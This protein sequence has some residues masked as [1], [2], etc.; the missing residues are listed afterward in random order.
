MSHFFFAGI[1]TEMTF[2]VKC[3][4]CENMIL[5]QTA[6]DNGGLCGQCFKI[7]PNERA[8][9]IL[10]ASQLADGSFFHLFRTELA[11][12][13]IPAALAE[14]RDWR[15]QSEY[16]KEQADKPL[17]EVLND[18]VAQV[19]GNVFLESDLSDQL[20]VGFSE[21]YA[22]CEYQNEATGE[23]RVAYSNHNLTE[24]AEKK[25]HVCQACPCCGVAM[26]WYPSRYHMPRNLAWD[27]V[28]DIV[29][30]RLTPNIQWVEC[31][32]YTRVFA[33]RG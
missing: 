21:K 29:A 2:R 17:L 28:R 26:Q 18:E 5:P 10:F 15:L 22:V 23:C 24:Q 33:G 12:S 16:Y 31:D 4:S 7:S 11:S 30:K 6:A 9:K 20:N 13:A 14:G 1:N 3:T 19:R 8:E 27:I 25:F 32:D